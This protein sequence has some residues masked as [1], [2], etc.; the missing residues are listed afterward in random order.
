M[1]KYILSAVISFLFTAN[2]F[3]GAST[4][5][6]Y[7]QVPD[8]LY[9][10]FL[11]NLSN[12]DKVFAYFYEPVSIYLTLRKWSEPW[13]EI[14]QNNIEFYRV[15]KYNDLDSLLIESFTDFKK[16]GFLF[17]DGKIQSYKD[18]TLYD[19]GSGLPWSPDPG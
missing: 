4:K 18:T 13:N 15:F 1:K 19:P 5:V 16:N 10:V 17:R 9:P 12:T 2:V 3:G 6:K 8:S 14:K 11:K 7:L